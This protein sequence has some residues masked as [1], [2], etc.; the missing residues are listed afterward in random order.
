MLEL[1]SLKGKIILVTGAAS[2]IGRATAKACAEAGATLILLDLNEKGLKETEA[3][4]QGV[5]VKTYALDLTSLDAIK[6]VVA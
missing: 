5:E 3:M 1:F 2:G 6:E 4:L